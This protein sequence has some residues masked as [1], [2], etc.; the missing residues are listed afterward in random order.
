MIR[1]R[2]A[3]LSPVS[4]SGMFGFD[5]VWALGPDAT[6]VVFSKKGKA[7]SQVGL[8]SR[9]GQVHHSGEMAEGGWDPCR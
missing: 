8:Q 1:S 6:Q 9:Y 3:T 7:F 2:S 4:G 5:L